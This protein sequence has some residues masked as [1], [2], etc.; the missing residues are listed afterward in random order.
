[1][2]DL[3]AEERAQLSSDGALWSD[4][5]G[6]ESLIGLT[7]RES[8]FVLRYQKN[9]DDRQSSSRQHTYL[10]LRQ[11]HASAHAAFKESEE[12]RLQENVESSL[13]EALAESFPA[14]DPAAIS[15]T[16]IKQKHL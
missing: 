6:H 1:M 5:K 11:R 2:L 4:A 7:F 12:V 15:I 13:D 3:N 8:I 9:F 16:S 14:S 10:Q